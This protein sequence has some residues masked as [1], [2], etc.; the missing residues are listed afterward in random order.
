MGE[1]MGIAH[2]IDE[3]QPA[4]LD[5]HPYV[6]VLI[7]FGVVCLRWARRGQ[8]AWVEVLMVGTGLFFTLY[9]GRTIPLGALLIVPFF[10]RALEHWWPTARA[11]V[12]Q[13]RE[14][15]VVYGGALLALVALAVTVPTKAAEP[16]QFFPSSYATSLQA[17]PEE[18]VVIN[19]L[20]DGGYLA[21]RH[22]DLQIVGDGLTD[23]YP[24][25]WLDSWYSSLLGAPDWQEFVEQS[26]ADYALLYETTP[27]RLGLLSEGWTTVQT[28]QDRLLLKAPVD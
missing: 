25:E 22:P 13:A 27:L 18:A 23:Q 24:V 12:S 5:M 19:E 8:V 15:L 20:A 2:Y 9:M 16:D 6:A 10:A 4:S 26:G 28:G 14:R 11:Q 1:N 7:M 3:Y 21:W 17:L